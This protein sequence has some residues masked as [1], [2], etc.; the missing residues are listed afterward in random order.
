MGHAPGSGG[1]KVGGEFS[2]NTQAPDTVRRLQTPAALALGDLAAIFDDLTTVVG[3]CERILTELPHEETGSNELT[4]EAL[5]TTALLSYRR[6]FLPGPRGMGLTEEDLAE[7]GLQGNVSDWH[8]VLEKIR[9]HYVDADVNP[10]Q[11]FAV[12]AAQGTDGQANGIAITSAPQPIPDTTT[13][14]QTG[15]L[16]FEL[17]RLVDERIKN[18]QKAVYTA[19]REMP[20][21]KL[22]SLPAI[23]VAVPEQEDTRTER[24]PTENDEGNHP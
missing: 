15:H 22:T 23:D 4:V 3:C 17:S 14:R 1:K 8:H 7:T 13:V 6:C 18:H 5:W 2:T 9:V 12:G 21:E 24:G 10:R 20:A 16:A 19:T 11:T